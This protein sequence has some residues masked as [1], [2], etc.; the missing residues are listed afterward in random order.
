[1][2]P[3]G[4]YNSQKIILNK[5][6][7]DNDLSTMSA[8]V[9][10]LKSMLNFSGNIIEKDS[11]L[12]DL[13]SGVINNKY[14]SLLAN[15]NNT[16]TS[17]LLYTIDWRKYNSY[18]KIGI[19]AEF[20]TLLNTFNVTSGEYGL[21]FLF[22]DHDKTVVDQE[23]KNATYRFSFNTNDLLGDPYNFMSYFK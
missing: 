19:S 21:E 18:K 15:E 7:R 1:M 3:N 16:Y 2:I 9:S 23:S 4:E 17:K 12:P 13:N 11:V 22:Y 8:Y 14:F 5:I 10:P 6:I 20:K